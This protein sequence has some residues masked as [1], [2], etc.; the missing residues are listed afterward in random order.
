MFTTRHGFLF[1][2]STVQFPSSYPLM[3]SVIRLR[4][5]VAT[6]EF[7]LLRQ[8]AVGTVQEEEVK[9]KWGGPST[10]KAYGLR[11]EGAFRHGSQGVILAGKFIVDGAGEVRRMIILAIWQPLLGFLMLGAFL[12]IWFVLL[13]LILI[14]VVL[15]LFSERR[16]RR[17]S[18]QEEVARISAVIERALTV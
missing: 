12:R 5:A 3:A 1:G 9:L 16:H 10:L 13:P 11:F 18:A 15:C 2:E 6:S 8:T 17:E 4:T 7:F 14:V